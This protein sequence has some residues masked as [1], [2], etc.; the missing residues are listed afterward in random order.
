MQ[1]YCL[2]FKKSPP[3]I[4]EIAVETA[5]DVNITNAVFH[6]TNSRIYLSFRFHKS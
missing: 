5:F 6:N 3:H 2:V 1:G 4:A